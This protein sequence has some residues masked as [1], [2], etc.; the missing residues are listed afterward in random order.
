MQLRKANYCA[1]K[2]LK[3][4]C[5]IA[6]NLRA[7]VLRPTD[8]QTRVKTSR[9]NPHHGSGPSL[10]SFHSRR[11][12]FHGVCNNFH[13]IGPEFFPLVAKTP[14]ILSF[15]SPHC[16]FSNSLISDLHAHRR[17]RVTKGI[18]LRGDGVHVANAD[19]KRHCSPSWNVKFIY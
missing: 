8:R 19:L 17:E 9:E 1:T 7:S 4:N 6:Q 13:C 16:R 14:K 18:L 5:S 15:R 12:V 2:L 10:Q 3:L 11:T